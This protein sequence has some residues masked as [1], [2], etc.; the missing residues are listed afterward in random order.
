VDVVFHFAAQIAIENKPAAQIYETNVT[1]TKNMLKAANY[2]RL[3]NSFTSA[4]FMLFRLDLRRIQ[5]G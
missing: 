5:L 4:V 1:G 3:K 2:A